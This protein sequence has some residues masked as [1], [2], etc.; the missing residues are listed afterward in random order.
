M[1]DAESRSGRW[2]LGISRDF[3]FRLFAH[4]IPSE[5]SLRDR[6]S[7]RV[8]GGFP[9][10]C[11]KQADAGTTNK[12]SAGAPPVLLRSKLHRSLTSSLSATSCLRK[13]RAP[14]V[15]LATSPARPPRVSVVEDPTRGLFVFSPRGC[16]LDLA[17]SRRRR[18]PRVLDD[19]FRGA[20][21]RVVLVTTEIRRFLR[22]EGRFAGGDGARSPAAR[23]DYPA[24]ATAFSIA[25]RR[26][27]AGSAIRLL[28][29][30][31]R[32][33]RELT[34]VGRVDF[35]G[36][37][38]GLEDEDSSRRSNANGGRPVPPRARRDAEIIFSLCKISGTRRELS[39]LFFTGRCPFSV[40]SHLA[41]GSFSEILSRPIDRAR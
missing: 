6:F 8:I 40:R 27:R 30:S 18:A 9:R 29:A 31:C 38:R 1:S 36:R 39:F 14:P 21:S 22:G 32:G 12:H 2:R 34:R 10:F 7:T 23:A 28:S 4:T 25:P 37:V 3:S 41:R 15:G 35:G 33:D 13:V 17:R 20:V 11:Q 19:R 16:W 26:S 24:R 5:I